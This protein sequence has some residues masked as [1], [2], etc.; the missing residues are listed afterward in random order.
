[1]KRVAAAETERVIKMDSDDTR[2]IQEDERAIVKYK[3]TD[4]QRQ[5]AWGQRDTVC[6]LETMCRV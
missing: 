3:E 2:H 1:M 4:R 6:K 5:W